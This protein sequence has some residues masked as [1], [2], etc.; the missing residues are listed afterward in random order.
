[1][2]P[3][4]SLFAHCAVMCRT[5][6]LRCIGMCQLPRHSDRGR[7]AEMTPRE[8]ATLGDARHDHCG[9]IGP[10]TTS[11]HP[12]GFIE[13]CLPT[14]SRTVPAGGGWAYEI[15]H[16]GFRFIVGAT[17]TACACSRGVAMTGPTGCRMPHQRD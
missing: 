9:R 11:P 12:P 8:A 1:M 5:L 4:V 15:K 17:A 2:I 3:R 14:V 10:V 6:S 13:P 7:R 16:D